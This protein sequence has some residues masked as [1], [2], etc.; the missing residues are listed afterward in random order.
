MAEQ[1][2][3]LPQAV[4]EVYAALKPLEAVALWIAW[5]VGPGSFLL[6]MWMVDRMPTWLG[7]LLRYEATVP[8]EDRVRLDQGS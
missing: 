6:W 3:Q 7:P 2:A 4:P 8:V 5:V 1:P